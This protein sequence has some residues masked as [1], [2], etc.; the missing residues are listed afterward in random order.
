VIA[1]DEPQTVPVFEYNRLAHNMQFGY[2]PMIPARL[3][4]SPRS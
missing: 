1:A 4:Q 2:F 3:K